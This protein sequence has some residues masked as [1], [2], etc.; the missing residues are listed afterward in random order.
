[1]C[2]YLYLANPPAASMSLYRGPQL[3]S[4]LYLAN[5]P[6]DLM[7]LYRGPPLKRILDPQKIPCNV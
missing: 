5:P 4:I 1:M 2:V 3:K 6:A 7:F